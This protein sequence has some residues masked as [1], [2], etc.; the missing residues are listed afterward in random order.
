MEQVRNTLGEK[1][2]ESAVEYCIGLW[3]QYPFEFKLRKRRV[4]KLGDYRFDPKQNTH[5]VTVNSD[6][7]SYQ[8][9]ITYA[10]ARLTPAPP[11]V[12]PST[13]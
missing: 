1:L 5:T 13:N 3:E 9:L 11:C 6:L 2:P 10:A 7:N 8:F 12:D 4:T